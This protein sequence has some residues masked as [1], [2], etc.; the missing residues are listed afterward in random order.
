MEDRVDTAI[1][2]IEEFKGLE[3]DHSK[4]LKT[5]LTVKFFQGKYD[6]EHTN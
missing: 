5:L 6:P 4:T 1:N 2:H 3:G